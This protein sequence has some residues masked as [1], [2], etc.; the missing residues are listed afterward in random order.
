MLVNPL[1]SVIVP[2]YNHAKFLNQ[3]L[4]SIFNQTYKNF[5]VILLDDLSND[6]S[7]AILDSYMDKRIKHRIYNKINS[8]SPFRQWKKGLDLAN[9][10]LVWIAESDDWAE[11][12]FLEKM[13]PIFSE[14][15]NVAV[16]YSAISNIDENGKELGN[17]HYNHDAFGNQNYYKKG[18]EFVKKFMLRGNSIVNASGVI[19]KK[20]LGKKYINRVID[21][22]M[23]GDWF[24]W[25]NLLSEENMY[26]YF[27]GEEKLNYFRHSSQSTRN[28]SSI[29]KKED[30]SIEA[31][32][33]IFETS[34]LINLDETLIAVKK[35]EMID[36]W[37]KEHSFKEAFRKSFFK[38]LKTPMFLN[39]SK[40]LLYKHFFKLKIKTFLKK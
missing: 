3:R 1:V 17:L 37:C 6:N 32:N 28:Y 21:Y 30:G 31:M 22:K 16:A 13:V 15:K 29:E 7:V 33:I 35:R 19:F 10:D 25:N 18:I 24:F 5:E 11:I 8:G 23:A 34:K 36:R 12:T 20:D 27:M 14:N 40:V 39:K 26:V 38:I 4:D 9:G 2:N